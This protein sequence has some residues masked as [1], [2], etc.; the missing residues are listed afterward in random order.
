MQIPSL[1]LAASAKSFKKVI[2]SVIELERV[3]PNKFTKVSIFKKFPKGGEFKGSYSRGQSL[4]DYP[5]VLL[6]Y[7]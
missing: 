5:H 3:K 4:V 2:D 7:N 1:L 6:S